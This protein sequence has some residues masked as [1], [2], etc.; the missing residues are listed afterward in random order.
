MK[1]GRNRRE[2]LVIRS[3]RVA[4]KQ[5]IG[6]IRRKVTAVVAMILMMTIPS[7]QEIFDE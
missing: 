1:K 6:K 2:A 5:G 4:V 7:G 3:T